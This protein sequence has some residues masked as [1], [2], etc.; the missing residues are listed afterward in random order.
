[1]TEKRHPHE[2]VTETRHEPPAAIRDRRSD[3]T[4]RPWGWVVC[5]DAFLGR[6]GRECGAI[7]G[8]SLFACAVADHHEAAAV[9]EYARSRGDMK[10]PRLVTDPRRGLRAG[11][12][13]VLNDRGSAPRWY[14]G[15]QG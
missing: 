1:M 13:L 5:T 4:S 15:E 3:R 14:E 7:G 6:W 9:E 10:R 8:R 12:D 2:T 11:D